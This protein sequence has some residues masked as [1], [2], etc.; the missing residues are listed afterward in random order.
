MIVRHAGMNTLL[1][2]VQSL[3]YFILVVEGT[4]DSLNPTA[5]L[6]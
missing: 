1:Y 6:N 2:P 5:D 4:S 3:A